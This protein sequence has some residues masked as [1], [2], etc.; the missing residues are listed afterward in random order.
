MVAMARPRPQKATVKAAAAS[1]RTTTS[2]QDTRESS[3]ASLLYMGHISFGRTLTF[4][5]FSLR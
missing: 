4:D 5:S 1:G 3:L 2:N